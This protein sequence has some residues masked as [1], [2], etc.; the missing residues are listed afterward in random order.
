MIHYDRLIKQ[1]SKDGQIFS[2]V[3]NDEYRQYEGEDCPFMVW[4]D[5]SR[6]ENDWEVM[7]G[8]VYNVRQ[9]IRLVNNY[10]KVRLSL[11]EI[12]NKLH[13]IDSNKPV[14]FIEY[15]ELWGA[16]KNTLSHRGNYFDLAISTTP[17][18]KASTKNELI[19]LLEEALES[20]SMSGYKGGDFKINKEVDV[21]MAD[22]G[23][24]GSY[25]I[26]VVEKD[27]Y[28]EFIM[29]NVE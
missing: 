1:I 14:L 23:L 12:L 11:G 2:L 15:G 20:K 19:E 21:A 3:H 6:N 27:D 17:R 24:C 4:R 29:E 7:R 8:K 28:I 26:D 13:S 10:K 25:I 16:G 5:G 22:Y 9:F 18:E